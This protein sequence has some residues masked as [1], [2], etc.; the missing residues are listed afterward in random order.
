MSISVS[1]PQYAAKFSRIDTEKTIIVVTSCPI[2]GSE[3]TRRTFEAPA[4]M[5]EVLVARDIDR[6]SYWRHLTKQHPEH[7]DEGVGS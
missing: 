5:A 3:V 6:E 7:F 4:K 2:C 1:F